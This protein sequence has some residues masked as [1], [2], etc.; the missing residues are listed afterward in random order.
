MT[1]ESD[2]FADNAAIAAKS[3]LPQFVAQNDNMISWFVLVRQKNA[4]ENGLDS[5][6][7]K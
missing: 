3:P 6:Q 5:E 2:S 4:A 7:W 1:V